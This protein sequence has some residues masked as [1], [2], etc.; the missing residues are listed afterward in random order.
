MFFAAVT[1]ATLAAFA[2]AQ[3][4]DTTPAGAPPPPP[5]P[6]LVPAPVVPPAPVVVTPTPVNSATAPH[7][8]FQQ[9]TYDFGNVKPTDMVKHEFIFTN[10]GQSKLEVSAVRPSCGCTTAGDWTHSVEPG[11]TGTIPIQFSPANFSGAVAKSVTV[12]CNDPAQATV[13]L[14]IKGTVWKPIDVNPRYAYF[15]VMEG[16]TTNE[17]KVVRITNNTEENVEVSAP[18]WNDKA[19][20]AELKTVRPGKEWEVQV[21]L[22]NASES[23]RAVTPI[24][25]KTSSTNMPLVT[26]SA[27]AMVQPSLQVTPQRL[28]LPYGPMGA[29]SHYAV[30]VRNLA[31]K[32][33]KLS[34]ANVNAPGVS[35]NIEETQPGRLFKVDVSFPGG[36]ELEAGKS[37]LL[38]VKSDST[39]MP[40]IRVPITS[41]SLSP[42][43]PRPGIMPAPAAI[44]PRPTVVPGPSAA[45]A[46]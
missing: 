6:A 43:P 45:V 39:S 32:E 20:K 15:T 3:G 13:Y 30:T 25:L 26:I 10:T 28:V 2:Q 42:I 31:S 7:I 27:Y 14:Q 18:E 38:S 17:T 36:F 29:G 8:Q 34:E 46:H 33:L 41:A 24:N 16:S 1:A 19:F 21:T 44:P 37:L 23:S 12:T 35:V 11:K 22:V 4:A 40:M 9:T 5:P